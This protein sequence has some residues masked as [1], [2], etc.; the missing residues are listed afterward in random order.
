MN[1]FN[2]IVYVLEQTWLYLSHAFEFFFGW[3]F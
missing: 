1:F 2:G 3:L